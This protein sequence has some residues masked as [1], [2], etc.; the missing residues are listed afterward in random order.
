MV[1]ERFRQAVRD[2]R[3]TVAEDQRENPAT[4]NDL[5]DLYLDRHSREPFASADT[6]SYRLK[7]LCEHFGMKP[8]RIS[9]LPMSRNS[10]P[11]LNC[12]FSCGWAK[13]VRV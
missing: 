5:A 7:R 8:L 10:S 6:I 11:N 12:R 2:E 9:A 13:T 4:F 1:Y 3:A